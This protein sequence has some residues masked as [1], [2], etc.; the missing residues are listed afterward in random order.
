MVRAIQR[1]SGQTSPDPE[2]VRQSI[3]P[4]DITLARYQAYNKDKKN[5]VEEGCAISTVGQFYANGDHKPCELAHYLGGR[6]QDP[7]LSKIDVLDRAQVVDQMIVGDTVHSPADIR[8]MCMK[9]DFFRVV[10]PDENGKNHTVGILARPTSRFHGPDGFQVRTSL[11]GYMPTS[12]NSVQLQF[13]GMD[14]G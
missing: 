10:L 7:R 1:S 11:Y 12:G 9:M 13:M 3:V 5:Q 4:I 14:R 2:Q 6:T 8:K